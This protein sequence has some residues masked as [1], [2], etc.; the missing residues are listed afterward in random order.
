MH[1]AV[2]VDAQIPMP[3]EVVTMTYSSSGV[4]EQ[5]LSTLLQL[6]STIP[7]FIFGLLSLQSSIGWV[8]PGRLFTE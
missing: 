6:S 8:H 5:L 4:P 3:Q 7:G 2:P 1:W